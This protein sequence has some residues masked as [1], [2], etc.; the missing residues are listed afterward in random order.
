MLVVSSLLAFVVKKQR[1]NKSVPN[2]GYITEKVPDFKHSTPQIYHIMGPTK[3]VM[4]LIECQLL[5]RPSMGSQNL[6]CISFPVMY[7]TLYKKCLSQ[8]VCRHA[9]L[10]VVHCS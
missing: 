5:P 10:G 6:S 2:T 9:L 4:C 1:Q 3:K 7:A 8:T